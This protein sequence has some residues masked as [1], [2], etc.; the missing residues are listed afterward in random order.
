MEKKEP[1]IKLAVT[2]FLN[3]RPLVYGFENGAVKGE[4]EIIY[5]TPAECSEL[6]RTNKV[7]LALLP[8]IEY[9]KNSRYRII[10]K[11]AITSRGPVGSVL[12]ILKKNIEDVT[13]VAVDKNSLTSIALLKILC[14]EL[15]N[16]SPDFIEMEPS[17]PKMLKKADA[18]LLIGDNALYSDINGF[19]VRDLGSD[20]TKMTGYPFVYAIWSGPLGKIKSD[21]L[22]SFN[23]SMKTGVLN[24]SKIARDYAESNKGTYKKNLSYLKEN[25]KFNFG[26]RA[27]QGLIEFYRYAEYYKLIEELPELRFFG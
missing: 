13:T 4:Y 22:D 23:K 20:W 16:I 26:L 7:D 14:R 24:L 8:S 12:L 17:L 27:Q 3:S 10:D 15:Y 21:Y 18:A 25:I 2:N 9:P 6:L 1:K 11:V 19:V 5:G